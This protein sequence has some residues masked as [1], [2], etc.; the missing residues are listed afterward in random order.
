LAL[1]LP[2]T[3]GIAQETMIV[4][5]NPLIITLLPPT[6]L[7]QPVRIENP[8]GE[9]ATLLI[10]RAGSK[11]PG[12]KLNFAAN[13]SRAIVQLPGDPAAA[14]EIVS[15]DGKQ[16]LATAPPL[17][18]VTISFDTA[19]YSLVAE[20]DAHVGSTQK[21]SDVAAPDG[22]PAKLLNAFQIDYTFNDGWK[23]IRLAARKEDQKVDGRPDA[24]CFWL[25]GD[26]G[27]NVPRM[28]FVDASGQ[29]FQP[30]G[31]AMH[32]TEWRF[33]RFPLDAS[34][35][36]WGGA[37]DGVVHYPIR[38]D[39]L[40]LIDSAARRASHGVVYIASPAL[41]YPR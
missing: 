22:A 1:N 29:T 32:D 9:A 11:D 2:E 7:D 39:T 18:F 10:R 3:D 31:Q 23:Y 26:A 21:L 8:A 19:D 37:S 14:V 12:V 5:S 38:L 41:I 17:K 20:G 25:K 34:S 13:Q 15:S 28:R 30:T 4:V 35:A 36:H 40:L 6:K 16:M 24:V 27:G 33:I